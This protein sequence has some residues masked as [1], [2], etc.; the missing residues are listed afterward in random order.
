MIIKDLSY[1]SGRE[2]F[3]LQTVCKTLERE[4]VYGTEFVTI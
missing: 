3:V 1:V 2:P 4:S